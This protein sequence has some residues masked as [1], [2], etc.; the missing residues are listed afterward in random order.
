MKCRTCSA[1]NRAGANLCN[2][3]GATQMSKCVRCNFE[4][5]PGA[6]FCNDCGA[7][8][9]EAIAVSEAGALAESEPA[10]LLHQPKGERR[11]LTVLFAD[12]VGS[13]ELSQRFDPED[14]R[15]IVRGYHQA[16]EA[17]VARF[18]GHIA[19]YLGDGA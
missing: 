8:L 4:N 1:E 11:H 17:V 6:K 5:A 16:A 19:Q 15:E 18:G 10:A 3:C 13:T 14:Y 7:W 2:T 9:G 12:L